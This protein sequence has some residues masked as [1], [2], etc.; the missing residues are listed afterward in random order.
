MY[1]VR[2]TLSCQR[3][4]ESA[5]GFDRYI[6]HTPEEN[7]RST[8]AERRMNELV[9]Q[10]PSIEPPQ[11]NKGNIAKETDC[12]VMLKENAVVYRQSYIWVLAS[13]YCGAYFYI[14]TLAPRSFHSV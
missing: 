5:G 7:L 4:I 11:L 13:G 9:A 2:A 8:L 3:A 12:E 14:L 6:Y 1:R 10:Y